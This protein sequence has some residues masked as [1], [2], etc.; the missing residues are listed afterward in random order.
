M[1]NESIKKSRCDMTIKEIAQQLN[2]S[3]STVSKALNGATDIS[4]ETKKKIC[5]YAKS[6]GYK[7]KQ[8]PRRILVLF[9]SP[10]SN[11]SSSVLSD[12]FTAFSAAARK[13][14]YEIICDFVAL[15]P[16]D[17]NLNDYLQ[18]NNFCA[19]FLLGINLYSRVYKQLHE[20]QVPLVLLD[21]YIPNHPLIASVSCENIIAVQHAVFYLSKKGHSKIGF[22][23]GEP[24]SYV[25]AERFSGYI[26]GSAI[27]GLEYTGDNVFYGD[28]TKDSGERAAEFFKDRDIT[29]VICCSDLM[30]IGLIDGLKKNGIAVPDD[31]SVIGFDDMSWIKHTAYQLTTIKQD[32][33]VMGK[34]A[35]AQINEM[36]SGRNS[37]RVILA[38]Q[39]I[40]RSTV[41]QL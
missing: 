7:S 9:E 13:E 2:I 6:V 12:I 38:H 25:S 35:L 30:A 17:F 23:A 16:E 31:I 37:Q 27:C 5:D 10:D 36:L 34:S 33:V 19:A 4:D 28:F 1:Y 40:E 26:L 8:P 14:N 21:N 32:F 20:T 39:L 24:R 18:E 3:I 11:R 41:K 29:A 22:L 15:Q